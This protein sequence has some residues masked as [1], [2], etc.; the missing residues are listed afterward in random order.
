[1]S[2]L[3][4]VIFVFALFSLGFAVKILKQGDYHINFN[5]CNSIYSCRN[6]KMCKMSNNKC[7]PKTCENNMN[8]Y[9]CKSDTQGCYYLASLNKCKSLPPPVDPCTIK[10]PCV[11]DSD[12][13]PNKRTKTCTFKKCNT[14]YNAQ[15]CRR[16]SE[17][18]S[19]GASGCVG[20][21]NPT[22]LIF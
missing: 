9:S 14:I 7:V 22:S 10:S 15:D 13:L 3:F 6:Y 19:W 11:L 2:K 12:C 20:T 5:L 8:E 18:C 1:M 16:S 17:I 21:Q 4:S